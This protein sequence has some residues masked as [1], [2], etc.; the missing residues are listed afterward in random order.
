MYYYCN[1]QINQTFL[2]KSLQSLTTKSCLLLDLEYK[3]VS[4]LFIIKF[5]LEIKT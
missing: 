4:W 3:Y 1:I 2:I 5:N